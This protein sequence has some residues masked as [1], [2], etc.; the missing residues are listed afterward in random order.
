MRED[1]DGNKGKFAPGPA[2][3]F[4]G[5]QSPGQAVAGRRQIRLRCQ[6]RLEMRRRPG[7]LAEGEQDLAELEMH[8]D[9]RRTK[10][11]TGLEVRAGL[12]LTAQEDEQTA[13]IGLGFGRVRIELE[14]A[15][16]FRFRAGIVALIGTDEP[17]TKSGLR[18]LRV[19]A[20][21]D[22]TPGKLTIL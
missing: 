22:C 18:Q 19:E 17:Q 2:L 9:L 6:S 10:S 16:V 1:A 7:R 13:E 21:D 11:Q 15:A 4:A 14:R 12:D 3:L 8:T 5:G 20:A